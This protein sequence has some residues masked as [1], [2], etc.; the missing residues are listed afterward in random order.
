MNRVE[1]VNRQ[2]KI[3]VTPEIKNTLVAC[4]NAALENEGIDTPA[5][6]DVTFVSDRLIKEI[7]RD[8]RE[9]NSATDVLSFPMLDFFEGKPDGDIEDYVDEEDGYM[10][11][12]D[13]IISL[14]RAQAQAEEYGH[15]FM[16]EVGFLCVHSTL[17]LLGYDHEED[18]ESRKKMRIREEAALSKIGLTR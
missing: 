15:S 6:V 13:I 17:H 10:F 12:G 11:L 1:F 9:K 16:R 8:Y 3:K 7:N 18:E 14:E 4:V 2:R 5:S